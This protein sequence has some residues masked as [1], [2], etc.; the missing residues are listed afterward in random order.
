MMAGAM[1]QKRQPISLLLALFYAVAT[2]AQE[3]LP[4][5]RNETPPQN[6]T[7]LWAGYDPRRE[8]VETEVCRVWKQEGVVL[9]VVRYRIGI[10]RG[11]KA[12]M[13]AI[14]GFPEGGKSLP[15]LLQ[16][17][18][19]GQ[20]ADAG[21]VLTNAKRGYACLS[22]NW[23]GNPLGGVGEYQ[24]PNTDWGA[25][26]AT[27]TGHDDH[28]TSL[29]PDS[30]TMDSV[31]SP[32]NNNWFL[33]TLAGRRAL[34]FLE[35][36]PEVNSNKLGV[37][38][39][40]MGGNLALYVAATDKR[41]KAAATSCGG[42]IGDASD[43]IK[44]TP[45]NNAAYA[46][47]VACPILFLNP[48][49]DFH[50]T[51]A[52]VEATARTVRSKDCHFV[53]APHVNHNSPPEFIAPGLLWFDHYLKGAARLPRTPVIGLE[54]K[55]P[56][57]VPRL[58]VKPDPS[59]TNEAVDVYYTEQELEA[60]AK[61]AEPSVKRFWHHLAARKT[62]AGWV[63]D[64]PL[65][66]VVRPLWAYANVLYPLAKPITGTGFYCDLYTATSFSIASSLQMVTPQALQSAGVKPTLKPSRL[67]ESFQPGWR[68]EWYSAGG[69]NV[70]THKLNSEEWKAPSNANLVLEVLSAQPNQLVVRLSNFKLGTLSDDFGVQAELKGG[71]E[72]QT[73][74]LSASDFHDA[75]D[76]A[77][78]CWKP[79]SELEL[80]NWVTL[81]TMKD[82]KKQTSGLGADWHGPAPEFR[83]LRWIEKP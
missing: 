12:V 71:S 62:G 60:E 53:R 20:H 1:H 16:M 82:G 51:I 79:F 27:Q 72:W 57:G 6:L 83:N 10:F 34:T 37:F 52:G 36:Q 42:G 13:A 74:A 67:I 65:L 15:G 26:D 47:K 30:R 38:G 69:W 14:Y 40:S 41:V 43:N 24:G 4:P 22:I 70:C 66:S 31:E 63:A 75:T 29:Q 39:H 11:Q 25:V 61:L 17:H 77:L 56:G 9:R 50:G 7:D 76:A 81:E 45:F 19:G 23:G 18:G 48:A 59:R 35:Q 78:P 28:Y 68:G 2:T 3:S 33:L 55:T 54:L 8:P 64:L 80:A 44:D 32:R 49:N 21:Y 73:V 58:T 46:A 5:L